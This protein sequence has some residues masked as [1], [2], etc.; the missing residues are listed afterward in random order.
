MAASLRTLIKV[1]FNGMETSQFTSTK[2]FKVTPSAGK[3]IILN[4]FSGSQG[5][6]L[7]YFQ[8]HGENVNSALY[9]E[10]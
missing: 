3:V 5:V 10:L 8:K 2:K 6:P 9:C 4:A 7:T 1:C